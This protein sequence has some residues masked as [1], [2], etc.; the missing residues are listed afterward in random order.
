M[1]YC[2][3]HRSILCS[4]FS[5]EVDSC[6]RWYLTQKSTTEQH[7]E[8]KR[9]LR[10]PDLYGMSSSNLFPLVLGIYAEEEAERLLERESVGDSKSS[11]L[12]RA[13]E[14]KD[15]RGFDSTGKTCTSSFSQQ[16]SVA[17][18]FL[19]RCGTRWEKEKSLFSDGESL[20]LSTTPQRKP[21]PRDRTKWTPDCLYI[22]VL[23]F[24]LY[25]SILLGG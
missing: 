19:E 14:H 8:S 23:H 15:S 18:S 7:A 17:N 1:T 5:R 20:G 12:T 4:T 24:F 3:S 22:W 16:V 21:M 11:R 2:C 6:S 25:F 13:D 9:L 10:C